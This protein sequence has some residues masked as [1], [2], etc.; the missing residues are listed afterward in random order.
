MYYDTLEDR[1]TEKIPIGFMLDELGIN[2]YKMSFMSKTAKMILK[3][4]Q[5]TRKYRCHLIGIAPSARFVNKLFLN[6][7]L[8]DCFVRKYGKTG[9]LAKNILINKSKPIH[10]IPRTSIPFD[11]DYVS[12]FKMNDPQRG[13]KIL[14]TLPDSQRATLIYSKVHTTRKGAQIMGCSHTH[15]QK[16]LKIEQ[17]KYGLATLEVET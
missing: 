17:A 11:S 13:K 1:L 12:M 5:L 8:L 3:V 15:F 9:C 6:S 14:K 2:L 4:C 10:G 16:L 7:D